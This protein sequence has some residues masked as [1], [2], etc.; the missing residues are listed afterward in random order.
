MADSVVDLCNQAL[1]F[2][3]DFTIASLD[4]NTKSARACSFWYPKARRMVLEEHDWNCAKRDASLPAISGPAPLG[5]S[6]A[7]AM[8]SDCIRLISTEGG[9]TDEFEARGRTICTNLTA[10]L[11]ILYVADI[12]DVSYFPPLLADCIAL[13]LAQKIAFNLT[14]EPSFV[15]SV[16]S[17]FERQ[18]AK[19]R[20]ADAHLD[21]FK[22]FIPEDWVNARL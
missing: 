14:G 16:T 11:K 10:P 4:E 2:L 22:T 1:A 8:P 21:A 12:E 18:M 20:G 6:F 17:L 13:A 15:N 9:L 7:Y 19:A 3:G 5:W